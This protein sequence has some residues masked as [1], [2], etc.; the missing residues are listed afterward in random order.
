MD[1]CVST[2]W[3][4]RFVGLPYRGGGRSFAGVDCWGLV[5]LV[6]Q[7]AAKVPVPTYDTVECDDLLA[8]ARAVGDAHTVGPWML[9][10]P[11]WAARAFDLAVMT[12]I[13]RAEGG[14]I[15]QGEVHVGVMVDATSVLHTEYR[16]ESVIV[17]LGHPTVR[18]RLRKFLRH[19]E[20]Q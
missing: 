9:N 15:R 10:P 11:Q 14:R 5:Y 3:A 7:H 19:K 20:L 1:S 18:G 17:P 12:G 16:T 13:A 6:Y 8:I 2:R 4:E